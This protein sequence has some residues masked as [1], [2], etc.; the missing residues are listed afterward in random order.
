M[1][2]PLLN[3]V[4]LPYTETFEYVVGEC[5]KADCA[6]WND[7]LQMCAVLRIA[8]NLGS[9]I[10]YLSEISGRMPHEEER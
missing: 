1:K 3:R 8:T 4:K 6:W 10:N 7:V 9:V 5:L 2:C